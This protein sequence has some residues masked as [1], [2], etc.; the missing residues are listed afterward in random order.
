MQS[1][2]LRLMDQAVYRGGP[3]ETE[4]GFVL[5]QPLGNWEST[6]GITDT[7]GVSTSNDIIEAIAA[8]T[9]PEN[10]LVALGYA[11]WGAGQLEQEMAA[12]AWLSGPADARIIFETQAERRWEEAARLL[13]VD[14]NQLTGDAG[15]A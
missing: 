11:G 3:V 6:L 10:C 9:G 4:R 14:I 7:L 13:G 8:G 5:H 12:N 1:S 15:H 2:T